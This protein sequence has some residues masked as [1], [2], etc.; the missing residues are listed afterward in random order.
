[1][2]VLDRDPDCHLV[3]FNF[4]FNNGLSLPKLQ[5]ICRLKSTLRTV[6]S[7]LVTSDIGYFGFWSIPST[8]R[9]GLR[10]RTLLLDVRGT[11]DV[12]EYL[13]SMK[14]ELIPRYT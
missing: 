14:E 6:K 1:M 13:R 12:S 4:S 11:S 2:D 5:E 3:S 9:I 8:S 7:T 10:L